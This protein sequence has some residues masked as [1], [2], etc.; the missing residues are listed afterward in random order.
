MFPL[1]SDPGI[2]ATLVSAV[3]LLVT[4]P[5]E[6]LVTPVPPLATAS[7]PDSPP[8]LPL[9]FPLIADPGIVLTLVSDVP[10]LVRYPLAKLV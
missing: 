4:Y 2:L 5:L 7:V 10:L 8:A 6:M 9:M 1:M 3:P